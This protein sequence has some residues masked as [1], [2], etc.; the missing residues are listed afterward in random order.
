MIKKQR[1][2][3][4]IRRLAQGITTLFNTLTLK[5]KIVAGCALCLVLILGASALAA[6]AKQT[7]ALANADDGTSPLL[8]IAGPSETPSGDLIEISL[9]TPSIAPTSA[10]TPT[11]DPTLK[12]GMDDERVKELQDRLMELG[13][14]DLDESTMHFGN[15]TADAVIRFQRQHELQMDGIAGGDTLL[16]IHSDEAKPYTLLQGTS[17]TDVDGFQRRLIELGYL[18]SSKATGYY[19]DETIAAVKAFQERNNLSADGKAGEKTFDLIYSPNAIASAS[20]SQQTRRRANILEMIEVAESKLGSTYVLGAEGSKTF[21]C[22]GLVY[23]CLKEAGSNRGRYNA[24]GYAQVSDWEKITSMSNLEK[25]DLLF[26]YNKAR[27]K[28]G[29]VGIYI[30]SGRMIDASSSEGKVVKRSCTT[31]WAKGQFVYAR[32]PW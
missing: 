29:H 15:A 2:K 28:I 19:G 27:T 14:L 9:T 10:P 21:D 17:G 31:S 16:M 3:F 30:G 23:Y 32:R 18:S 6:P 11:P 26:F 12:K 25:G 13:Y 4:K 7:D 22:S 24:A 20:K 1:R 8:D 5:G